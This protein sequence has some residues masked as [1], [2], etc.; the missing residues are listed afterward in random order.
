MQNQADLQRE[1]QL[2]TARLQFDIKVA[3]IVFAAKSADAAHNRVAIL[4][5]LFPNRISK[6]LSALFDPKEHGG[7]HEPTEEK[8]YF[9]ELLF[10]YPDKQAQII[11]LWK[12]IFPYDAEEGGWLTRVQLQ[13]SDPT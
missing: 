12:Q 10:K 2:E 6:Q 7:G 3:E 1:A 5:K 4:E 8:K 9:L 13:K 11:E